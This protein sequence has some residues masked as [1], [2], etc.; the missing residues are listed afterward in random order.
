MQTA[1]VLT[2]LEPC[3]ERSIKLLVTNDGGERA[4]S[5]TSGEDG[6]DESMK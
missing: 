5:V 4:E 1:H 2:S 6:V 3:I